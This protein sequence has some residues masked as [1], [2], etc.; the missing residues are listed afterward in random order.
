M[1]WTHAWAGVKLSYHLVSS[2]NSYSPLSFFRQHISRT[3]LGASI[4]KIIHPVGIRQRSSEWPTSPS[5]FPLSILHYLTILN[6]CWENGTKNVGTWGYGGS[7]PPPCNDWK[8]TR[9][10]EKKEREREWGEKRVC[11]WL[12][13]VINNNRNGSFFSRLTCTGHPLPRIS[14]GY[15]SVT[16]LNAHL[17]F[18][19]LQWQYVEM[20]L[21]HY[22]YAANRQ[23]CE[24]AFAEFCI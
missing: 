22:A 6:T 2:S 1:R 9:K 7:C 20:M 19:D 12:N 4:F 8:G 15:F 18:L 17:P 3:Y 13:H 5:P 10:G 14:S 11:L 16:F 21:K 23:N 24:Y